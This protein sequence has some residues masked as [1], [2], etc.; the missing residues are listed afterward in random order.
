ML[1]EIPGCEFTLCQ[2]QDSFNTPEQKVTEV[3]GTICF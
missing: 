2:K 3:S 1:E